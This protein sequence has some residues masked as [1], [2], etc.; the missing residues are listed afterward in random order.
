MHDLYSAYIFIFIILGQIYHYFQDICIPIQGEC[1]SGFA[2]QF[3][4]NGQLTLWPRPNNEQYSTTFNSFT[5]AYKF[6]FSN[7]TEEVVVSE[8]CYNI[9]SIGCS[10]CSAQSGEVVFQT[11]SEIV[12]KF[13]CK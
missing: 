1:P 7:L 5:G 8:Y 2:S 4:I 3:F 12:I 11:L 9:H 10:L 6:C 13:S